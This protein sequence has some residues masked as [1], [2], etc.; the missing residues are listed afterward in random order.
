MC[1]E[2]DN[3]FL[4]T[5][6]FCCNQNYT[7]S[8]FRTIYS[9]SR[10]IFQERDTNDIFRVNIVVSTSISGVHIV[11]LHTVYN[12]QW[13]CISR[14]S[15]DSTNCKGRVIIS[16]FTTGLYGNNTCNLTLQSIAKIG[17]WSFQASYIHRSYRSGHRHFLLST[18][19]HNHYL[20]QTG[21]SFFQRDINSSLIAHFDIP[22]F[23]SH[24]TEFQF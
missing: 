9:S 2:T 17:N 4:C 20:F 16:R 11:T 7:I 18:V 8:T 22:G 6:T 14:E 21:S 3:S 12:Y 10:S 24:K 13:R 23:I 15:T 5:P 19:C 1:V